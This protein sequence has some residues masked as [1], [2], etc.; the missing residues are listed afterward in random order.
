MEKLTNGDAIRNMTDEDL[1]DMICSI[2]TYDDG[3]VITVL[4]SAA[5]CSVGD[6]E[7]WIKSEKC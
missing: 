2:N 6:V 1:V 7:K 5:M 4:G 3:S